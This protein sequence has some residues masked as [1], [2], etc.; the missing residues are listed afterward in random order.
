MCDPA[1][2]EVRLISPT[3]AEGGGPH[4]MDS[5]T[6]FRTFFASPLEYAL[7]AAINA[8]RLQQSRRG[9]CIGFALEDGTITMLY[10]P[11]DGTVDFVPDPDTTA[12]VYSITGCL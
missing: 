9:G 12:Q 8:C 6:D 10:N 11:S 5:N 4:Q 1:K 3:T 2:D 7:T